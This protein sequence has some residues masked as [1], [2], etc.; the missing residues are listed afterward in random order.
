MQTGCRYVRILSCHLDKMVKDPNKGHD[1]HTMGVINR[2][3]GNAVDQMFE[4][5]PESFADFVRQVR[6]RGVAEINNHLRMQVRHQRCNHCA[7]A[8]SQR[9]QCIVRVIN[10]RVCRAYAAA[11]P[12]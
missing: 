10:M 8:A 1:W 5:T 9:C 12:N 4:A 3:L 11:F 6:K 2:Q 7:G